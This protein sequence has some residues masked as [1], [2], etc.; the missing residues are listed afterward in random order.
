MMVLAEGAHALWLFQ[1]P[2]FML[3]HQEELELDQSYKF[4][5]YKFL[6]LMEFKF[7]FHPQQRQIETLGW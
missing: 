5:L 1:I 3:Q 6:A 4:T 7:V 2:E